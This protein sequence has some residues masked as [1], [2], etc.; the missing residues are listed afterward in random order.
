VS[1]G[2]SKTCSYIDYPETFYV[3]AANCVNATAASAWSTGATP[4][5]LCRAGT[6][7]KDGLLS[8]WGASDVGYFKVHLPNDWDSGASLDISIDLTSTDT[9]NGHT[10]IMQAATACA[11]GDGSTTDDVAFNT[12]QSFGT[13]TLNGNANRT[14]N[15]T[16]TGLTKT[17]CIAGSTLWLKISRTTDTATNVGVYGATVDLARLITVQAN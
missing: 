10:I 8:P 12:A 15:A 7:N 5:S 9:T 3:P 1:S 14:W 17:G 2:A 4:A 6:N 11:K 13:I 16:L